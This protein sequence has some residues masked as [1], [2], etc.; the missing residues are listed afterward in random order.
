MADNTEEK[1]K[2]IV[3]DVETPNCR[4][5]SICSIAYILIDGEMIT[6]EGDTFVDPE[7]IF[8]D[9]NISIHGITPDM[10]VGAPKFEKV[11]ETLLEKGR[12]RIFIAH[13]AQFDLTVLSKAAERRLG[14]T[15][16]FN[17][18]C[19]VQLARVLHFN[20][21]NIKGDLVLSKLARTLGI[22]L[23]KHHNAL[24]DTRAC[25]GIFLRL[26]QMYDFQPSCFVKKF[27]RKKYSK[28]GSGFEYKIK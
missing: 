11:L 15:L 3:I 23:T 28:P 19:T 2:Y 10:V 24:F 13:N 20:N 18:L 22:E 7:D 4:N 25:A 26:C 8:E 12:D 27:A 21:F 6:E 5:D 9:F 16:D 1:M 14:K 17:Y